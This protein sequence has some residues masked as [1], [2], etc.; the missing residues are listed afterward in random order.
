[1]PMG[2]EDATPK[3][4]PETDAIFAHRKHINTEAEANE[5]MLRFSMDAKASVHVGPFARGGK[6]RVRTSAGDHDVHPEATVTPVGMFLS[7]LE[8]WL[9]SGVTSKVTSEC[10][11][12][13]LVEWWKSVKERFSYS[14]TLL[15]T[16]D[17]GPENH[18]RRPQFLQ[19]LLA[20]AHQS[21]LTICLASSP[22]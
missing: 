10:R 22:P 19:R 17:H 13:R 15:I 11:G 7:A 21:Q 8:E 12:D 5:K 16:V 9:L 3:N 6:R 4:R 18:R 1:M 20:C 2:S 14:K